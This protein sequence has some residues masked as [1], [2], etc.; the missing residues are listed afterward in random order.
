MINVR[1]PE[2]PS[3]RVERELRDRAAGMAEGDQFPPVGDLAESHKT[4]R[5]TIQ[6]VMHQLEE[7]G[8]VRIVPGW[9]TFKA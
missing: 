9:G 7:S 1:Q 5:A 4:S 2:R 3:E 6:R 8:V